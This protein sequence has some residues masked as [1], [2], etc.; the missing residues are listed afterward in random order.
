M[1]YALNNDREARRMR[2]AHAQLV[3][4]DELDPLLFARDSCVRRVHD[5]L[6]G[7][8]LTFPIQRSAGSPS[9]VPNP[10]NFRGRK[11]RVQ[12]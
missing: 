5:L 11:D 7:D 3:Y 4:R 8:G 12:R 10:G 2:L 9:R 1:A 6:A